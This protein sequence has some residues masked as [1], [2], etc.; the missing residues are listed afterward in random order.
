VSSERD[1]SGYNPAFEAM[2]VD[3]R[4]LANLLSIAEHGSFNRAA[5]ARGISQPALSNSIAQLERRLGVQV[6]DRT[7]RGSVLTEFGK[8]LVRGAETV[9]QVLSHMVEEVRLKRLGIEGPLHIG[10]VPSVAL[11]FMPDVLARFLNAHP[12]CAVTLMEGLDDKLLSALQAGDVDLV[13]GPL[14]GVFPAPDDVVEAPLFEDPF[15]IGLGPSHPLSARRM[16]TLAELSD[17]A[18]V[19]PLPGNSYRRHIEALFLTAG[20]PWPDNCVI[21]SNLTLVE[22]VV[23]QTSRVTIITE[24]QS[25][26]QNTWRVRSIPLKGGGQRTIGI[27]WRKTGKLS[28]VGSEFVTIAHAV[29]GTLRNRRKERAS[30]RRT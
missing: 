5:A 19:L 1:H 10:V 2:K 18:W 4:H 16:L 28:A 3:P 27:K 8:I 24:L 23:A 25:M 7:R 11:K 22:S 20:I 14:A 29:A 13:L 21:T 9:D 26:L 12:G 6:L 15:S 17:A 30:S